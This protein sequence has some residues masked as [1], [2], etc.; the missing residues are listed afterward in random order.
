MR[1]LSGW[2]SGAVALIALLGLGAPPAGAVIVRFDINE[3]GPLSAT[4]GVFFLEVAT[5]EGF[6]I[7]DLM[8]SDLD[9]T[10]DAGTLIDLRLMATGP[11]PGT[12]PALPDSAL[13]FSTLRGGI[14]FLQIADDT[15]FEFV[16]P[17]SDPPELERATA[18]NP[19]GSF[20]P[21]PDVPGAERFL[22]DS[23]A[24]LSIKGE[25][26]TGLLDCT[27]TLGTISLCFLAA[28]NLPATP[29][30]FVGILDLS[31]PQVPIA[32]DETANFAPFFDVVGLDAIK[33]T[34]ASM[35][36]EFAFLLGNFDVS[37]PIL[38][39]TGIVVPEPGTGLGLAASIGALAL[40]SRRRRRA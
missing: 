9:G 27:D 24:L 38:D 18:E 1:R 34:P 10:L 16:V 35:T 32:V 28:Q 36:G 39:S 14:E 30:G 21:S 17:R 6:L 29:P 31:G 22:F 15:P 40:L 8:D 11:I 26:E 2:V 12:S 4:G 33:T 7:F 20:V 3:I 23:G 25:P 37:F 5:F 19:A 13:E